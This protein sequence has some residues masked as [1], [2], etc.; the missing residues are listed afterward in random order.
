[1]ETGPDL[2]G[3]NVATLKSPFR[4][5]ILACV[6]VALCYLASIIVGAL[7][8]GPHMLSPLWPSCALLASVLLLTPR[9]TWPILIVAAFA[10]FALC[11]VGLGVPSRS[12]AYAPRYN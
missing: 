4:T 2:L 1:M 6:T 5:A 3:W 10:T 9:R 7:A 11:D 12:I 8:L